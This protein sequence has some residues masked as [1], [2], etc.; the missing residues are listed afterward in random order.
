MTEIIRIS[1]IENYNLQF[2]N[3]DLILWKIQDHT[4][5]ETYMSMD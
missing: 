5:P 3:G 1:N 2:I 4:E